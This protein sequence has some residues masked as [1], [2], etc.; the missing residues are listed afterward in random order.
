[1]IE[2]LVENWWINSNER[3]FQFHFAALCHLRGERVLHL[4]RHCSSEL[5]KDLITISRD[6]SINLYQL[7]T[8]KKRLG[9]RSWQ[10]EISNQ[11]G[12][13]VFNECS[14]PSVP[15][16]ATQRPYLVINGDL[17]E[18]VQ[19]AI[20]ERNRTFQR[21]CGR[22]LHVIVKGE[23]IRES[24]DYLQSF[25]P[26]DPE[27]S[28]I[29]LKICLRDG[30][31]PFDRLL[32]S[33][34]LEKTF[35]SCKSRVTAERSITFL[36]LLTS[37]ATQNDLKVGNSF[38]VAEAWIMCLS[39]ILAIHAKYKSTLKTAKE[40]IELVDEVLLLQ[41][42]RL[43]KDVI[44]N[45][46]LMID[47][48][49]ASTNILNVRKTMVLGM[50]SAFTLSEKVPT[51]VHE[52]LDKLEAATSPLAEMWGEGAIPYF[53]ATFFSLAKRFSDR[54]SERYLAETTRALLSNL[55]DAS[56]SKSFTN[57]FASPELALK[58]RFLSHLATFEESR[59]TCK[60]SS[61]WLASLVDLLVICDERNELKPM[62]DIIPTIER[63]E[64]RTVHPSD[65][66]RYLN[67][68]GTTLYESFP[69]RQSWA[70]L[71]TEVRNRSSTVGQLTAPLKPHLALLFLS[72]FP[73]RVTRELILKIH[74][75]FLDNT[76]VN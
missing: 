33:K 56:A 52:A 5:G 28:T 7:K 34:L 51:E 70:E 10:N 38:A 76:R 6:K 57:V 45:P 62:W 66:F 65:D 22:K 69:N 30:N 48:Y 21:Q 63:V 4:T 47:Y 75:S 31:E 59:M 29:L 74:N 36:P 42:S 23:L 53:L 37:L 55:N 67:E 17:E 71:Q 64:F 32:F 72:V 12:D 39:Y 11:I 19:A 60:S 44:D 3:T 35:S 18:E 14:H 40:T 73:Q 27:S 61:Y 46:E 8:C 50:L 49:D 16:Q 2:K 68:N 13:L 41:A 54:R 25:W 15:E 1:V 20:N 9:I 24:V 43:A 26:T 58:L